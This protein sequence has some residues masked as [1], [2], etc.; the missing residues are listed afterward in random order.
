MSDSAR[1]YGGRSADER[2]AERRDRFIEAGLEIFGTIGFQQG[3]VS[4][5]CAPPPPWCVSVWG[6]PE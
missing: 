6:P 2:K 1:V 3:T 4:A 5:I